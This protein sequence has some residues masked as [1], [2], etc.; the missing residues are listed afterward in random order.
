MYE[1]THQLSEEVTSQNLEVVD[2]NSLTLRELVCSLQNILYHGLMTNKTLWSF[3]CRLCRT[4][5]QFEEC[6]NK[7]D[8]TYKV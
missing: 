6:F 3:I 1:Y 2:D 8:S 4:Q 7:A 5:N